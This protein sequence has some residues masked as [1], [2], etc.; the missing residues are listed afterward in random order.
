MFQR[1]N[2]DILYAMKKQAQQV[3][4]ASFFQ[5]GGTI[6]PPQPGKTASSTQSSSNAS[7]NQNPAVR[8]TA[9]QLPGTVLIQNLNQSRKGGDS[10]GGGYN[11]MGFRARSD[12]E[13]RPDIDLSKQYKL[14][15]SQK[16]VLDA[17]VRRKSVFF[18]G[19]AGMCFCFKSTAES[20]LISSS[21]VTLQS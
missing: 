10:N 11:R 4:L 16:R 19:A 20:A 1:E 5:R 14:S 6:D 12:A 17:I 18:T 9:R 8:K 7:A 13:E 21:P 3:S 15:T 2:K